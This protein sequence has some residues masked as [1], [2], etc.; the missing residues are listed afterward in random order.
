MAVVF[1]PKPTR[2][3]FYEKVHEL[4]YFE[5]RFSLCLKHTGLQFP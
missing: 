2:D 3:S 5:G 1:S 4:S